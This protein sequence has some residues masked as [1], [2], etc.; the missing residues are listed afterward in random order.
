MGGKEREE[1]EEERKKNPQRYTSSTCASVVTTTEQSQYLFTAK[2]I[3]IPT[4][5]IVITPLS[6][7]EG[8]LRMRQARSSSVFIV[9]ALWY[10]GSPRCRC[11]NEISVACFSLAAERLPGENLAAVINGGRAEKAQR[12][13]CRGGAHRSPVLRHRAPKIGRSWTGPRAVLRV[14][15]NNARRQSRRRVCGD[16]GASKI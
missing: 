6:L 1:E 15:A 11:G 10:T 9:L 4:Q 16:D 12:A 13:R 5:T 7:R 14:H 2:E 8:R 3:K